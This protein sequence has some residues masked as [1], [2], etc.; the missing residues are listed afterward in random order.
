[1]AFFKSQLLFWLMGATD[2]HAKNFSI[3]LQP[4]GGY[5]LTPFYDV[6][7]AQPA[8]D[9]GQIAPD[10][11]RIAMSA[12]KNL[13]HRINEVMGRN[14][15]QTGKAAGLG[16]TLMRKAIGDLLDR[17]ADVAAIARRQIPED[18]AASIHDSISAAL[19]RRL[20]QIAS[21][22]ADQ[23]LAEPHTP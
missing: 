12:G 8:V 4:G 7:S 19:D 13:H 14:F 23:A 16:P 3:F 6:L 11:F 17:S 21:A 20:P 22:L 1:M 10:K 5:S 18:F 9:R 15:V 2:G